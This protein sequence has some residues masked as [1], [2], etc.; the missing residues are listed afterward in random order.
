MAT[1]VKIVPTTLGCGTVHVIIGPMFAGK[2]SELQRLATRAQIARKR[3]V[4]VRP[5][6][7]VRPD[8]DDCFAST[9]GPSRLHARNKILL[10]RVR[11]LAELPVHG[12]DIVAVDEG[13]FFPDIIETSERWAASGIDVIIAMLNST[14]AREDF[15][16]AGGHAGDLLAKADKITHLT[17]VCMRCG[18]HP[19]AFSRRTG[20]DTKVVMVGTDGYTATCRRCYHLM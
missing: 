7:D 14:F 13:Q 4:Y 6:I 8:E 12:I 17:A 18:D 19:A 2:T 11:T 16:L 10:A 5:L 20:A 1:P 15:P 3:C 9:H